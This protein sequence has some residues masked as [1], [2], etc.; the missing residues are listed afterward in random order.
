M[1]FKNFVVKKKKIGLN[2]KIIRKMLLTFTELFWSKNDFK[3]YIKPVDEILHEY[4]RMCL[5]A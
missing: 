5:Y 2:S 1:I 3:D 4:L